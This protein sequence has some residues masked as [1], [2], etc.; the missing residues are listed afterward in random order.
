[1]TEPP[2]FAQTKKQF[3]EQQKAWKTALQQAAQSGR[4][5]DAA[6]VALQ[7]EANPQELLE[8]NQKFILGEFNDLP[9]IELL[10]GSA[11]GS[12]SGAYASSSRTIYINQI[13]LKHATNEQVIDLL[14]EE[15]GHHLDNN[16][17]SKDT[18]GDEGAVFSLLL[19]NATESTAP[20]AQI[21]NE[22]K[23][24]DHGW[25]IVNGNQLEAEFQNFYGTSG[26]DNFNGTGYSDIMYGYGGAD[27]L[28]GGGGS[29]YI[30]GGGGADTIYDKWTGDRD[31]VSNYLFGGEGNDT[32]I[33]GNK[34][35]IL[36][37]DGNQSGNEY[38]NNEGNDLL[39]G[40]GG[41]DL[42]TGGKS[43][44]RL[45]GGAGKDRFD[46]G[47]G[48][49]IIWG[50]GISSGQQETV[51]QHDGDSVI[52]T[53]AGNL[54]SSATLI[55]NET[56]TFGNGTD[57]IYDFNHAQYHLYL[58]NNSFNLLSSGDALTGLT[59]GQ[60]YFIQG[61]WSHTTFQN[62]SSNYDSNNYSGTFT[63]GES[64]NWNED[65]SFLVLYNAQATDFFSTSNTNFLVLEFDYNASNTRPSKQPADMVA[66]INGTG[67]ATDL[68]PLR[69]QKILINGPSGNAGDGSASFSL[70]ENTSAVHTFS[71]TGSFSGSKSIFWSLAGGADKSLFSINESTGAL[72]F[73]TAPSYGNNTDD[74]SDGTYEVDVMATLGNTGS[75]ASERSIDWGSVN[76]WQSVS[77]TITDATAPT[78]QSVSSSTADGTYKAGDVITIN[79]LFSE[80]V[81]VN[82]TGGTPQLTL[83]TGSTDQ[84]V[85]YS[86]GSGTNTL[87]FSY[88]VQNGDTSADL[89][90]KATSSL[91]L[92]GATI[93]DAAGNNATL[94][95]PA[96]ASGDSLAGNSA[97]VI[98]TTA[99]TI[100]VSS[101]V[102]SLKAGE[103]ATL[104]F[105]LSEASTNFVESD[106]AVSGGSLS[107]FSGSG[108][109]YSATFTPTADSTTDGVISV[110]SSKFSDATG[111]NNLDGSD[112]NNSLTL[113]VDTTTNQNAQ[114]SNNS[115]SSAATTAIKSSQVVT[116]RREDEEASTE[117]AE[118]SVR[119]QSIPQTSA[120]AQ[121]A[122]ATDLTQLGLPSRNRDFELGTSSDGIGTALNI[123]GVLLTVLLDPAESI[124]AFLNNLLLAKQSAP[125]GEAGAAQP[126][127]GEQVLANSEATNTS[128][129]NRPGSNRWQEFPLVPVANQLPPQGS[130][131]WRSTP[132]NVL[133]ELTSSIGTGV[134]PS[135]E[136]SFSSGF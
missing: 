91:A 6:Q 46:G 61:S 112:S 30:Y 12:A 51:Y 23:E 22:L 15:L 81:T 24:N 7:L 62:H 70:A 16:F 41:N 88:T 98:D 34:K 31:T 8:L 18:P 75:T 28:K 133:D 84:T 117:Q 26:N 43:E 56:I 113:S 128:V 20:I 129:I 94:T 126:P 86:S 27:F 71:S 85:S 72:S 74:N 67:N 120:R 78:V 47:P 80:A 99:P 136:P 10:S 66:G 14:N 60:N 59:I 97:L 127:G 50:G 104:S 29:D 42:L 122:S 38:S 102:A 1:M 131:P 73:N 132:Q 54:A 107:N 93:Q 68:N 11:I 17:Q 121:P 9:N 3:L 111:N 92:N 44:D 64:T 19:K 108:T 76:T 2:A 40:H 13:W 119:Y 5:L 123:F 45:N 96:L 82:T 110:A 95:L 65:Y 118:I 101:D 58:P 49:D 83:E 103:T 48:A 33:G 36:R 109:S 125:D 89:N 106:I 21:G 25:I 52:W 55:N 53:D 57:V 77:I 115:P 37:G 32:I 130:T 135:Q 100:A 87:A 35:D 63:T 124:R 69:G 4:F 105:S 114:P 134:I 90:Y 116:N 39:K 79:V